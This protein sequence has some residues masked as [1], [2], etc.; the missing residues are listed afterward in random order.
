M[1]NA[2]PV[3]NAGFITSIAMSLALVVA[4]IAEYFF[5]L[6]PCDLCLAQRWPYYIGAPLGMLVTGLAVYR[7][8]RSIVIA[9]LLALLAVTAWSFVLG[10]HH[11]GVEFGWWPAPDTCRGMAATARDAANLLDQLIP[12]VLCDARPVRA[13]G[14]LSFANANALLSAALV[15]LNSAVLFRFKDTGR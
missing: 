10:L 7:A 5:G 15:V 12:V 3:A 13:L 4:L 9:G 1:S 14:L 11:S 6:R 2:S 8:P